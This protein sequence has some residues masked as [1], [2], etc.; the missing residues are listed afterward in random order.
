MNYKLRISLVYQI[1]HYIFWI[2]HNVMSTELKA[3]P[4]HN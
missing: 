3:T 2:K 4:N 1:I